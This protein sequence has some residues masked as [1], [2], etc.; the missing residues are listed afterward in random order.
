MRSAF[1]PSSAILCA[2]VSVFADG[3]TEVRP[4]YLFFNDNVR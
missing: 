4:V 2:D 3:K 1:Q